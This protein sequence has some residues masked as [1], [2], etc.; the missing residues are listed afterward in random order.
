MRASLFFCVLLCVAGLSLAQALPPQL[1]ENPQETNV[2]L[3]AP[4]GPQGLSADLTLSETLTGRC[5][6]PSER[7]VRPDAWRCQSADGR[8]FDPCFRN[9]FNPLDGR[10]ACLP[11]PVL[12]DVILI[13]TGEALVQQP[14]SGTA[15]PWAVELSNGLICTRTSPA[16]FSVGGLNAEYA[17]GQQT[18]I[19]GQPEAREPFWRAYVGTPGRSARLIFLRLLRVWF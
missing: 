12:T 17:C 6:A 8:S 15:Q 2:Y 13:E 4:F 16:P 5:D 3:V 18:Y 14:R 9:T 7:S 19:F 1:G 11:N 10:A